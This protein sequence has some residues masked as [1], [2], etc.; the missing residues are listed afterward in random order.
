MGVGVVETGVPHADRST[1]ELAGGGGGTYG[2]EIASVGI[3]DDDTVELRTGGA[4]DLHDHRR[5]HLGADRERSRETG[6]LARSSDRNHRSDNGGGDST[7]RRLSNRASDD[8]V[9]VE[10]QVRAV[11]LRG[12]KRQQEDA[13]LSYVGVREIAEP[14]HRASVGGMCSGVIPSRRRRRRERQ[15]IRGGEK[16]SGTMT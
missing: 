1:F 4:D 10:R 11:L 14:G 12:A 13:P 3:D 16:P 5:Q 2:V 6:M 9:G 7:G 8:R 15:L